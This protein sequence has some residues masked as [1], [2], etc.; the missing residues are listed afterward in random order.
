[1]GAHGQGGGAQTSRRLEPRFFEA[2]GG[3]LVRCRLCPHECEI[4]PGGLGRCR[5]RANQGGRGALP[6]AG[7]IAAIAMDPIEKKPLYHFHPGSSILSVGFFG[8]NFHCPFCQ[9]YTISQTSRGPAQTMEPGEIVELALKRGSIGVAYTYSEPLVHFE[10][11]AECARLARARGLANVLVSNG[12]VSPGPAEELLGLLDAANIDLKAWDPDFYSR[13]VGGDLEEV[14]R[15]LRQAVGRIHLEV[16]TL[17]I[18]TK[19]DDPGQVEGMAAFLASLDPDIPY[20]LSCYAPTY[21]YTI[22]ATPVETVLR[23]AALARRRLRFVYAGNVGLDET[24][25]LCP[26][27]GALLVRRAGYRVALVGLRDGCCASCGA[28][29]PF[30]T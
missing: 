13:E 12:F 3:D 26:G 10:Y 22:P 27:C 24:N 2:A 19:N 5:V 15:F 1:M 25:T 20:H 30:R 21:R 4:A 16:T 9:N 17:V 8:C 6:H 7:R 14:C 18:P 29:A 23:L 28:A 11:V